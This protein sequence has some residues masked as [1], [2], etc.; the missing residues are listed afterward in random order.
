MTKLSPANGKVLLDANVIID[1]LTAEY[2]GRIKI[3]LKS[4][5]TPI[6]ENDIWIAAL[7]Q[8]YR[9]PLLTHDK[10]MKCVSGLT[11]LS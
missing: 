5:G 7:A 4:N 9:L 3:R 6:P 11:L 10:H 1:H 2:Y 8:Q